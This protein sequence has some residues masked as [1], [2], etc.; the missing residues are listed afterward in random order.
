MADGMGALPAT[1]RRFIAIVTIAVRQSDG[2]ARLSRPDTRTI[3]LTSTMTIPKPEHCWPRSTQRS[4]PLL[5]GAYVAF[6]EMWRG[7]RSARYTYAGT[8]RISARVRAMPT[9]KARKREAAQG[10]SE[11]ERRSKSQL[12]VSKSRW[13][14]P[15]GPRSNVPSE[16]FPAWRARALVRS[17]QASAHPPDR[18]HTNTHAPRVRIRHL[19]SENC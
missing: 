13:R 16:R 7:R 15:S 12:V 8:D 17:V 4:N 14:D 6:H 11:V 10:I 5:V 1:S 18:R 19:P 2:G 9:A 3:S